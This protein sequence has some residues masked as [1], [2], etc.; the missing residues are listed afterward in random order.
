MMKKIL[1]WILVVILSGLAC[2]QIYHVFKS[3][4]ISSEINADNY[5]ELIL[6]GGSF[7][8]RSIF[9]S[10][11]KEEIVS[12]DS[13]TDENKLFVRF[14]TSSCST[15]IEDVFDRL[16]RLKKIKPH[17]RI[18]ALISGIAP[19]EMYVFE[20]ENEC[21]SGCYRVDDLPFDFDISGLT[22]FVFTIQ[23]DHIQSSV[24]YDSDDEG[25]FNHYLDSISRA[26]CRMNESQ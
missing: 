2:V 1:A 8:S 21:L 4:T 10:D 14:S 20:K 17:Q 25:K 6:P 18:I 26:G 3:K 15:C 23:D 19:R 12:L 16:E 11:Y 7:D 13:I 9:L 5:L 22:P 24:V